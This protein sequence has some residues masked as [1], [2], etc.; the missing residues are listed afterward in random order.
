MK[1]IKAT[2]QTN[3]SE[4]I[5]GRVKVKNSVWESNCLVGV[6]NN[7]PLNEGD[8]VYVDVSEGFESPFIIGFVNDDTKITPDNFS[9]IFM[10]K[11]ED[12]ESSCYVKGGLIKF[13]GGENGGLVKIQELTDKINELVEWCKNH[14]HANAT[15][16]GT[17]GG[18]TASGNL[19]VPAPSEPPKEMN[20]D[21]YENTKITH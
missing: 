13:N 7:V 14:T 18:A 21:D 15:F 4:D 12:G 5:Y 20:K 3:S 9:R 10:S 6:L 1:L 11:S 19:T 17:I 2:V 16:A 8:T